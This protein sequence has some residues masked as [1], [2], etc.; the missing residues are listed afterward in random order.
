MN[1]RVIVS[2]PKTGAWNMALDEAILRSVGKGEAPITLRLYGWEPA[3]LSLGYAQPLADVDRPRLEALGWDL[4]R[5]P[6]GGKAILHADEL[7]YSIAGPAEHPV[8]MGGIVPSYQRLSE[9]LASFLRSL[10]LPVEAEKNKHQNSSN[11]ICFEIPGAHEN[12][13]HGK[14]VIGNAQ[15]RRSR[16]VLQHGSIPL[17]GDISRIYQALAF[18]HEEMREQRSLALLERATTIE[19]L[20]QTSLTW[21]RAARLLRAAFQDDLGINFTQS[22]PSDHELLLAKELESSRYQS[23]LWTERM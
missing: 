9:P 12:T 1:G 8:F 7:T 19:S 2:E 10:D 20:M 5:R 22:D 23:H 11:P 3:C 16:A 18:D 21:E 6:T 4:I 13:V 17:S 15:L 14:K